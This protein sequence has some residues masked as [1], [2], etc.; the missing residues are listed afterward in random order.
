[1]L[2]EDAP[3][4]K[5][6]GL[7]MFKWLRAGWAGM[8]MVKRHHIIDGAKRSF[9]G[10]FAFLDAPKR[11]SAEEIVKYLES[12]QAMDTEALRKKLG[13]YSAKVSE[14]AATTPDLKS[15]DFQKVIKDGSYARNLNKDE[16]ISTLM[17]NFIKVRLGKP[18]LAPIE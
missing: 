11:P 8:N 15:D 2:Y 9:G 5:N 7:A 18:L 14:A 3:G 13:P 12:L 1:V 4:G 10:F 17:V 16:L 6:T